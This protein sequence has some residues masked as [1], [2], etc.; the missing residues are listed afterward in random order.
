MTLRSFLVV[1]S[2]GFAATLCSASIAAAAPAGSPIVGRPTS[3]TDGDT[4]RLGRTRIRLAGID[5]P[6]RSTA[7][8]VSARARLV[9]LTAGEV[10]QCVDTG[11]RSY[12]RVVATCEDSQGRDLARAMVAEGWAW[13]WLRYSGGRYLLTELGARFGRRGMF[14]ANPF[15]Q[16]PERHSGKGRGE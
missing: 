16:R 3:I 9:A 6:E 14:A 10:I 11:E 4:L 1:Q 8:G 5:A 2:I 12:H 7:A 13:D 15:A